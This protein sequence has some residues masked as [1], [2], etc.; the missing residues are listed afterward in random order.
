[1][2]KKVYRLTET[3]FKKIVK[4]VLNE[5]YL[6]LITRGDIICDIICRRKIAAKGSSGDVIKMIQHILAVHG[7]NS[8][9]GGGGMTDFCATDWRR[10]DGIFKGHTEDAVKEFQRSLQSKYGLVVDGI[11][12][13]NTW[14]AMCT[15]L[16][17]SKSLPKN[18]FC[19]SCDCKE[20]DRWQERDDDRWQERDEYDPIKIIDGIDCKILKDCVKKHII[21]PAPDYKGFEGCIGWVKDDKIS[22]DFSCEGCRKYFKPGYINLMPMRDPTKEQMRMFEF[23]KWCVD[24]CDGYKAAV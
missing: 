8:K 22:N 4:N 24:N 10:C 16:A 18:E 12:G 19:P 20:D 5:S 2:K 6:G 14:K 13:Y 17:Y 3:Q 11:V 21:I 1:M 9:Y 23:G 7:Y 15:T